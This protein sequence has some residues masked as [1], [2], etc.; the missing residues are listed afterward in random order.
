MKTIGN[1]LQSTEIISKINRIKWCK[2]GRRE[3]NNNKNVPYGFRDE[4]KKS[5]S[6][7]GG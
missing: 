4:S 3:P 6:D 2:K 7:T 5:E 1:A